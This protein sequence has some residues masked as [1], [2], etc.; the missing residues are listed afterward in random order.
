MTTNNH[1]DN[2]LFMSNLNP[3]GPLDN[4]PRCKM[5]FTTVIPVEHQ[6]R[7]G[8]K[9]IITRLDVTTTYAGPTHYHGCPQCGAIWAAE[10]QYLEITKKA[11]AEKIEQVDSKHLPNISY[12]NLAEHHGWD[13]NQSTFTDW[14]KDNSHIVILLIDPRIKL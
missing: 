6:E 11:A 1:I 8:M 13:R 14:L 10:A 4:C 5:S 7:L 9:E 12:F 2:L 3:I